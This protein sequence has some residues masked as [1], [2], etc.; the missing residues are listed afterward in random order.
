MAV[1]DLD[2][3]GVQAVKGVQHHFTTRAEQGGERLHGRFEAGDQVALHIAER[4]LQRRR[5]HAMGHQGRAQ[6]AG[7]DDG[8]AGAVGAHGVHHMCGIA[9][10]RHAAVYPGGHRIAV[11]HGVLKNVLGAAQHGGHV[12][13]AV[14][15]AVKV[16]SEFLQR[17]TPVP[18]ALLPA[19]LVVHRD[20]GDPVDGGQPCGRVGR[21]DGVEHHTVPQRAHA[22]K[23]S[24]R[25]H[26]HPRRGAAPHDGTAPL[27]GRLRGVHLRPHGR[28]QAIGGDQQRSVHF[29]AFT[30]ACLDDR[31]HTVGILPVAHHPLP[32]LHGVVSQAFSHGVEQHHLQLPPVHRIL[33]PV[34][35]RLQAAWLGVHLVA[36]APHQRPFARL[37]ANGVQHFV[38]KPQVVQLPH[39]IGLQVDA[40]AQRLQL[41]H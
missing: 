29:P 5:A 18:V 1:G 2:D 10:Q 26:R 19:A 3:G 37:Q 27:D 23:R 21:C 13:P 38:A 9:Q 8:L 25:S 24:A 11:D 12:Q 4:G 7:I 6:H 15:P 35:A 17:H 41:G 39:G 28:V 30:I 40:H 34:V 20:L 14:V 32:Q 36:V 31:R 22:H 33:R 16:V